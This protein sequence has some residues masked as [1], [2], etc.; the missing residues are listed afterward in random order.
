MEESRDG[1]AGSLFKANARCAHPSSNG[2]GNYETEKLYFGLGEVSADRWD[3][4]ITRLNARI[5]S[6]LFENLTKYRST[7]SSEELRS[8]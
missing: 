2:L 5:N 8:D 3:G 7:A 1:F 6:L 4:W